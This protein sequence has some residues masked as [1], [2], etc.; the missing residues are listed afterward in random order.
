LL[1]RKE[2]R[3]AQLE[4]AH[5]QRAATG[6][7]LQQ[8]IQ[9]V[10]QVYTGAPVFYPPGAPG[11][12]NFLYPQPM[13]VRGR[14]FPNPGRPGYQMN[15]V[16]P[17]P[18]A[19]QP[20]VAGP[21]RGGRVPK[22]PSRSGPQGPGTESPGYPG[23]KYNPNVRNPQQP[24]INPQEG[25]VSLDLDKRVVG[26]Q[27]YGLV[28]ERMKDITPDDL[29]GKI[30]GM[31]LEHMEAPDLRELIDNNESLDRKIKEALDVLENAKKSQG[32]NFEGGDS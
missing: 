25:Q 16:V 30:T 27:L 5:A 32:A 4:Q 19:P 12:S 7:R 23:I 20:R 24:I 8:G 31:I 9:G 26:E 18:V 2:Q 29:S 15:F 28:S 11:R 6:M 1:K 10:G 3:R 22:G 14:P 17:N 21:Q 13:G